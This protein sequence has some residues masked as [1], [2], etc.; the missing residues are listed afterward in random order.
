MCAFRISQ[1]GW[2]GNCLRSTLALL[3]RS[4]IFWVFS[5]DD[6]IF[7]D[8]V[9]VLLHPNHC[10][11]LKRN[12][13]LDPALHQDVACLGLLEQVD[14]L[15]D[16]HTELLLCLLA[17]VQVPLGQHFVHLVGFSRFIQVLGG[18]IEQRT[19]VLDGHLTERAKDGTTLLLIAWVDD[20]VH[21]CYV[22]GVFLYL[23][24]KRF[25]N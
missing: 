3:F 16:P 11:L 6:Q 9:W 1:I 4:E 23:G 20:V 14:A 15:L 8:V 24:G 25:L 19:L 18:K 2:I 10:A 21:P 22:L 12:T 17:L 13:F 5:L 7:R